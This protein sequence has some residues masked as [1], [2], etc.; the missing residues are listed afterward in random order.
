MHG[1]SAGV[2]PRPA[3]G[4]SVALFAEH[5]A[6]ERHQLRARA[7]RRVELVGVGDDP[8]AAGRRPRDDQACTASPDAGVDEDADGPLCPFAA[9]F[10]AAAAAAFRRCL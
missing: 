1:L 8:P 4:S 2:D 3:R 6:R 7:V 10:S 5:A 9:L